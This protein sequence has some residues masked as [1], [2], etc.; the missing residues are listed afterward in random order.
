[1]RR[2]DLQ[3]LSELWDGTEEVAMLRV[4]QHLTPAGGVPNAKR[5]SSANLAPS[6]IVQHGHVVLRSPSR[7]GL[8]YSIHCDCSL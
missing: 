4:A 2:V 6:S 5:R 7:V 1:M 3:S 8:E